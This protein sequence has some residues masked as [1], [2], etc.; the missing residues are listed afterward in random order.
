MKRFFLIVSAAV[1][2]NIVFAQTSL[3]QVSDALSKGKITRGEFSLERFSAK[4]NRA[5]KSGGVFTF[6]IGHGM[7]WFTKNPIKTTQAVTTDFMLTEN[8]RGERT[9]IQG[10]QNKIYAQMAALTSAIFSG[11][12]ATIE[13]NARPDFFCEEEKWRV[14]LFPRD[15][16][17]KAMLEKIVIAGTF[18]K[19]SCVVTELR[20][21]FKNGDSSSYQLRGH[22]FFDTLTNNEK[23]FF[24]EHL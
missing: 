4:T 19:T 8:A 17:I 20:M 11:D 2:A 10:S 16:S 15:D 3:R 1:F 22:G 18:S 13:R 21:I 23:S 24:E 12:L 6:A 5:I 14:E 9:K 7:I